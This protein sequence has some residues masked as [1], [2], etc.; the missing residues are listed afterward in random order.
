GG[1]VHPSAGTL[2]FAKDKLH[3][4]TRFAE[5]G[6]PVPAFTEVEDLSTLLGFGVAH[7]WPVVLKAQRGGYG[8]RGG[9]VADG[10]E[11]A[12]AIALEVAGSGVALLA[13]AFVPIQKEL[14][15]LVARR[16]SGE[17][18]VYPVVETVQRDG[19]CQEVIAP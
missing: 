15:V 4:R 11:E 6:L 5:A 9:W 10:P 16:P 18:A 2:A 14:A 13:E 17:T 12:E 19:I 7:G 1:R 3:Q 8:G